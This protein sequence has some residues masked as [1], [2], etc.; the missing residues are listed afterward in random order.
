MGSRRLKSKFWPQPKKFGQFLALPPQL[1]VTGVQGWKRPQPPS[2]IGF[3]DI[4]RPLQWP[5][6]DIWLLGLQENMCTDCV[7]CPTAQIQSK[8]RGGP[9][10]ES[11]QC[12]LL[13]QLLCSWVVMNIINGI[14][15]EGSP[16]VLVPPSL[17][18]EEK[19]LWERNTCEQSMWWTYTNVYCWGKNLG[20]KGLT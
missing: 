10:R 7:W 20:L 2:H 17:D 11:V 4:H 16:C 12:P 9:A 19:T 5:W 18:P 8:L 14:A 1:N 13:P 3:N 15:S 6:I